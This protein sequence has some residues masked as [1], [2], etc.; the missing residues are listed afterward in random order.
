MS[1]TPCFLRDLAGDDGKIIFLDRP[2][3]ERLLER[4]ARLRRAGEQQA[5]AG[6]GI[7]PV[8]RASAGA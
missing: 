8:H 4:G 7:E 2:R 1:I 5:A 6:V 3:L